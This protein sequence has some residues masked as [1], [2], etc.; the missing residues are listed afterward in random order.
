MPR[1][2]VR[3]EE[4]SPTQSRHGVTPC[5]PCSFGL[6]PHPRSEAGAEPDHPVRVTVT[7]RWG[8]GL[9][10]RCGTWVARPA[11]TT[12]RLGTW[13]RRLRPVGGR[14]LSSANHCMVGKSPKGS[15]QAGHQ[16]L[17]LS[18][19]LSPRGRL[20]NRVPLSRHFTDLASA[21]VLLVP[22]ASE[23]LV[24]TPLSI[25]PRSCPRSSAA[26]RRM[27]RRRQDCAEADSGYAPSAARTS[28]P[29]SS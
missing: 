27:A 13:R 7:V 23:Y 4:G 19:L 24:S 1:R 8:P 3:G 29:I 25:P 16:A 14:G 10:L 12:R 18:R 20:S 9:T 6:L 22:P 21:Y 2:A 11:R 17:N 26:C 28:V 15:Q 5:M